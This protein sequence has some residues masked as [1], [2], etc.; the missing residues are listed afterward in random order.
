M[1]TETIYSKRTFIEQ[2]ATAEVNLITVSLQLTAAT[3]ER[4]KLPFPET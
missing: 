4:L 2:S 1:L 3:E